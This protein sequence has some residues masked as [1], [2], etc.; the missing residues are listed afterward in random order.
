MS[1]IIKNSTG[2]GGGGDVL[3]LT[4][5]SG[6]VIVPIAGN[7]NVF[8]QTSNTSA[9][10]IMETTQSPT[11]TMNVENRGYITSYVVD[12]SSTPGI[13]GTYTTIQD[14]VNA[15]VADG[16]SHTFTIYSR[17]SN[18]SGNVFVPNSAKLSFVA[19]DPIYTISSGLWTF[20]TNCTVQFTGII[21]DAPSGQTS[22][23]IPS[24][25][26]CLF[27]NCSFDGV[28]STSTSVS[29]AGFS[30]PI[31]FSNC[32]FFSKLLIGGTTNTG[33]GPL[34]KSCGIFTAITFGSVGICSIYD[35]IIQTVVM[36]GASS[37]QLYDCTVD[38]QVLTG[39]AAITGSSSAL[40]QIFNC[41]F[42]STGGI[43]ISATGNFLLC[44][45]TGVFTQAFGIQNLFDSNPTISYIPTQSGNITQ[46][47]LQAAG[48]TIALSDSFVG[49]DT[50]VS[51]TVNMYA[52]PYTGLTYTIAD[53]TGSA[54]TNNITVNGNG[55]NIDGSS[56]HTINSNYGSITLVYTG[57]IW[58]VT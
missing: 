55:S 58:K 16:N 49:I 46:V 36:S 51:R 27:D 39:N 40:S 25:T 26:V 52:T 31:T 48:Y 14:A 10:Q 29:I 33:I 21:F 17:A 9:S 43:G 3:S 23:T 45:N 54:A 47:T 12:T 53:V 24:N 50:S 20:G 30:D 38:S 22:L 1:Q 28:D 11:G 6:G 41:A 35:S 18:Y 2:G 32:S 5:D 13:R 8:G 57:T 19:F 37:L 56:S 34:F 44:G 15:A 42:Y 7:I 4:P